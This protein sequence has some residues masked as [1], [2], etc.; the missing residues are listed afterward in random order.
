MNYF[1]SPKCDSHLYLVALANKLPDAPLLDVH[2]MNICPGSHLNL[3]DLD[4]CLFLLG[5][6]GLF[7]LLITELAVIHDPAYRW[8]GIGSYLHQIKSPVPGLFQGLLSGDNTKLLSVFINQSYL[9]GPDPLINVYGA[10]C[11]D[12]APPLIKIL[13]PK[14]DRFKKYN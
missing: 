6:L 12:I 1:P 9:P 2:V 14:I 4:D 8:T 11:C 7:A 13:I 3:L 10:F 5:F